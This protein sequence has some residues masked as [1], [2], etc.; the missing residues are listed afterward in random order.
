MRSAGILTTAN[1]SFALD[2]NESGGSHSM[3]EVFEFLLM[4]RRKDASNG[5]LVPFGNPGPPLPGH[6]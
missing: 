3:N 1:I 6:I 2:A 5:S 4:M